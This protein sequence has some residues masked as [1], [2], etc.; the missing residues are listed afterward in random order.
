MKSAKPTALPLPTVA[1]TAKAM[2]V[3][4]A[5]VYRAIHDGEVDAR[6]I[7]GTYRI[8]W[9]EYRR[10]TGDETAGLIERDARP[11]AGDAPAV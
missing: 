1:E 9:R 8:P 7:R 11:N 2:D 4:P 10:L 3:H 5:T 6:K